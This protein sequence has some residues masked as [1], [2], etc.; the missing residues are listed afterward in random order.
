MDRKIEKKR[1]TPKRIIYLSGSA[2]ILF[3]II[4]SLCS[5]SGG[6]TLRVD[7]EKLIF[8]DIKIGE[9]QEF[10]PV[11]GTVMPINTFYL[12]AVQGGGVVKIFAEEGS[13][14]NKGDSI[15]QLENTDLHLDIMY[16][17][18]QLFEQI[19]NLRN[20]KLAIEQY[21]LSLKSE[22]LDMDLQIQKS[23]RDYEQKKTLFE[24]D[25]ISRTEFDVASD[26]YDYWVNKQK[27]TLESQRTDSLLRAIQLQQLE[28]SVNRMQNNLDVVKQKL[29]NLIIRA[30]IAGQLTSL[31]A[32]IGQLKS[33][34]E[35]LGQIDVLDGFKIR[36]T[37][38]EYY[39]SRIGKGQEGEVTLGD[40]S[41][42]L[43][44]DKVYT[45]V[46][47]G[48]FQIDLNFDESEPEGIRR[49]QTMRIRL[50]LGELSEAVLL[51]R[52]GF[53]N[54]TGG[55][56]IFVV[57]NSGDFA[58]RRNIKLGRMNPQNFEVLE[59]LEPGEKVIISSYDSYGDFERLTLNN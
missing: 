10:I 7:S 11:N 4:Y 32:E 24:K 16:R 5:V 20:T 19:N 35:R 49:G 28:A 23:R 6:A 47:D 33:R 42:N 45:E 29:E 2:V 38:D 43:K 36:A 55:N 12:D 56:W 18:A 51:A 3:L 58:V 50:A 15:L 22:V 46:I 31:N 13:V 54:E 21:S 1:W 59:G 30:P 53:Y 27:L 25:L 8:S 9:F 48:R 17:E 44:V 26:N 14:V 39:I 34:G 52:G 41:Y 40:N 57:D 37:V